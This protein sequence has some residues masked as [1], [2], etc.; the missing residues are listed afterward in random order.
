MPSK[1]EKNY[2][3]DGYLMK[4]HKDP[5]V[6]PY[7][8]WVLQF[9]FELPEIEPLIWRRILVPTNYNFWDLHVAVQD[10]MG[11]LDYHLHHFE[12]KGKGK[13]KEERIG[14]PDFDRFDDLPEVYP[15]WEIPVLSYYNDLGVTAKYLYD[16]GDSW[17][18]KIQL[19]GYLLKNKKFK[20]PLCIDGERACPPEDCGGTSGYYELLATLSNPEDE[21]YEDM[22]IWV[23]EN[24]NAEKFDKNKIEFMNPF[25]RWEN[26]FLK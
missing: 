16:Y 8:N 2:T 15:G 17:W 24:W 21:D 12:I 14:I 10:S 20:Y 9:K 26:A 4:Y 3:D 11:W 6:S 1:Y 5:N 19:E 25:K 23:G 13:R 18:H 22:K 7:K